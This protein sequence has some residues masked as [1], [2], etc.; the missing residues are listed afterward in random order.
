[1]SDI[2]PRKI[3]ALISDA[4]LYATPGMQTNKSLYNRLANE[5][6]KLLPYYVAIDNEA[7]ITWTLNKELTP[8]EQLQK[9]IMWHIDIA[10]NPKV[11]GGYKL[12]KVDDT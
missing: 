10:T 3:K 12:V 6:E 5:L 7:I 8:L 4:K 2:D 1:M 9:I 11:N